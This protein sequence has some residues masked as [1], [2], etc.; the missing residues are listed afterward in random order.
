MLQA[1]IKQ[2]IQTNPHAL[3]MSGD[4]NPI[5]MVMDSRT[6][7]AL[8]ILTSFFSDLLMNWFVK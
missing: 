5:A 3:E 4:L 6:W 8:E 1:P 7:Q 2:L